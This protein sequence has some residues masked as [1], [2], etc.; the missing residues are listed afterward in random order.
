MASAH[1]RGSDRDPRFVF[2]VA[3]GVT[4][5]RDH[6]SDGRSTGPLQRINPKEQLHEVV[7]GRE[8]RPLHQ[9]NVPPPHVFEHSHEEVPLGKRQGLVGPEGAA[10]VGGDRATKFPARRPGEEQEV[11]LGTIQNYR[12]HLK[13][14][15]PV[16]LDQG[17]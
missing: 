7:V 1:T 9:E 11:V 4:E 8:P 5:I 14:R 3:L 10:E 13:D 17:T 16:P 15:T 6:R 2:L 12:R